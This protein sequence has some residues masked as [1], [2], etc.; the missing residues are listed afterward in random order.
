MRVLL[1]N[2]RRALPV[3]ATAPQPAYAGAVTGSFVTAQTLSA[4]DGPSLSASTEPAVACRD[5]PDVGR[6][7][8]RSASAL[9]LRAIVVGRGPWGNMY[10]FTVAFSFSMLLGYSI[11]ARRYA[12]RSIGFIPLGVA[13][14]LLL[15]A[16]VACRPTSSRSCRPSRTRR[17]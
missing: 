12:I 13:L 16:V 6:G 2:G 4:T 5:R 1:A 3:L 11:L 8:S 7:R 14:A 9:L 10:E 17:C 15:Y